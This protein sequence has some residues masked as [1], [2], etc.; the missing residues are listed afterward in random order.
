MKNVELGTMEEEIAR[1]KDSFLARIKSNTKIG[2]LFSYPHYAKYLKV[3]T[4]TL[5]MVVKELISDGIAIIS[6]KRDDRIGLIIC[7]S[8][9]ELDA[10]VENIDYKIRRMQ[11]KIDNI[12]KAYYK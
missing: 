9:D 12:K 7:D 6:V 1:V 3:D 4:Y 5:K 2:T 10:Y 11:Q 8:E